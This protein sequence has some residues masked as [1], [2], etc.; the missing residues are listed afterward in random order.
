MSIFIPQI[1]PYISEMCF[2]PK[3]LVELGRDPWSKNIDVIFGGTAN[4]GLLIYFFTPID[5]Q[6][7]V[8]KQDS[9]FLLL[10]EMR[11][12]LTNEAAHANGNTLKKLYFKTE[13]ALSCYIDVSIIVFIFQKIPNIYNL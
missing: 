6:L 13:D 11:K 2:L 3:P 10:P 8:I 5:K 1:E 7:E 9:S 4:E 12:G